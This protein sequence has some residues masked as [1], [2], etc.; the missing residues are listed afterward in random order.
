MGFQGD[1]GVNVPLGAVATATIKLDI[2]TKAF[3]Y[4]NKSMTLMFRFTRVNS[5]LTP[6]VQEEKSACLPLCYFG[7]FSLRYP[8]SDINHQDRTNR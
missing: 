8:A 7:N 6:F 5:D 1:S 3:K 4:F 2:L